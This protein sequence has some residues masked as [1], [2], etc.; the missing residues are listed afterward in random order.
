MPILKRSFLGPTL[1]LRGSFMGLMPILKR[2]FL[3]P[4]PI[5]KRSFLVVGSESSNLSMV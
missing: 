5:L 3:G 2:L 1:I 4:T